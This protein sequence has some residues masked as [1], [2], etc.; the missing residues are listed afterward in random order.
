MNKAVYNNH[1]SLTPII[2]DWVKQLLANP[3]SLQQAV[4]RLQ[5]PLNIH[6]LTPFQENIIAYSNVFNEL[7]KNN[8]KILYTILL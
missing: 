8:V 1:L 3:E 4:E 7:H 2:H 5:S 6:C